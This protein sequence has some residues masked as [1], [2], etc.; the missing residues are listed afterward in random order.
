M[1]CDETF[2]FATLLVFKLDFA[3]LLLS[4]W[5]HIGFP[6]HGLPVGLCLI[7]LHL[8][9]L[10]VDIVDGVLL[11]LQVFTWALDSDGLGSL[12]LDHWL[13]RGRIPLRGDGGVDGGR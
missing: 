8:G 12:I 1:S 6:V 7:L 10:P 9:V 5:L 13:G 4:D 11:V 2:A 3:F